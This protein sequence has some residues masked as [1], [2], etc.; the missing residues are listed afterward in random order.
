MNNFHIVREANI[1][2][3]DKLIKLHDI[4][5]LLLF[6]TLIISSSLQLSDRKVIIFSLKVCRLNIREV[7]GGEV[8]GPMGR[9]FIGW[10]DWVGRVGGWW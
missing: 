10:R 7:R 2:P 1:A 4:A 8:L 3:Q 9:E 5:R 6:S